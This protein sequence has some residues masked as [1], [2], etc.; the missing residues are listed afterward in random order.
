MEQFHFKKLHISTFFLHLQRD[1]FLK[2]YIFNFKNH[3][4][5]G[6]KTK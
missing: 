4:L 6:K 2:K 3:K 1:F 5:I